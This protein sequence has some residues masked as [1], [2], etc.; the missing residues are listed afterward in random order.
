MTQTDDNIVIEN[1]I[2]NGNN[3][4][5]SLETDTFY[6]SVVCM[7]LILFLGLSMFGYYAFINYM[8]FQPNIQVSDVVS[9]TKSNI[10][11]CV[12]YM[13]ET[14]LD[15]MCPYGYAPINTSLLCGS[16]VDRF[17]N[18]I[19]PPQ[20]CVFNNTYCINSIT[21]N[22][23]NKIGNDKSVTWN[24]NYMYITSIIGAILLILVAII[25]IIC[26]VFLLNCRAKVKQYYKIM[27]WIAIYVIAIILIL[28]SI[29]LPIVSYYGIKGHQCDYICDNC[30]F[31][32]YTLNSIVEVE[33]LVDNHK[34]RDVK[35]FEYQTDYFSVIWEKKRTHWTTDY[36]EIPHYNANNISNPYV[37][38]VMIILTTVLGTC[39]LDILIVIVCICIFVDFR[40]YFYE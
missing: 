14:Y 38:G 11:Y 4:Q 24:N 36:N 19:Y 37:S 1:N 22:C 35:P 27:L 9:A 39:L 23:L 13:D 16:T 8:E 40:E 34:C 33:C 10:N 18:S 15:Y 31:L 29:V 6:C 32:N 25:V 26:S 21:C 3:E 7:M 20:V 12:T 2:Q 30:Y 28:S 5:Q 17:N